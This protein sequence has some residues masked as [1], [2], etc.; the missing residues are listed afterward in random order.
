MLFF[1]ACT[2]T[3][4]P[5]I[6]L[7]VIPTAQQARAAENLRVYQ[8][9]W[10]LVADRHYDPKLQGV[11]WPAAGQQFGAQAA[12][13][14]DDT[15]LYTVLNAMVGLL[16]DSH[17]RVFTP[18]QATER[19]R[20]VRALNGIDAIRL[21]DGRW[22]VSE[23]L[24]GSPAE[25]AGVRPGWVVQ[26]RN[27]RP[28]GESFNFHPRDGEVVRWEFLDARDAPVSLALT[29][30]PL[31]TAPRQLA[32]VL[33]DGF[34]YLRFD[35]FDA[36]DRRW[37]SAQLKEHRSAPGAVL[38]LRRNPGGDTFSLG[39]VIGE[40]FDRS[41]DC[42]TF[43]SRNGAQGEKNS[44]QLG[45]AHFHGRVA[46]LTDGA[47]GSAAEIF[48]AVLQAHGRA[49]VVGRQTAGAVLGSQF[50]GLSDGGELQLSVEDYV[51]PRGARLEGHGVTPDV[52]VP[53]M[54]WNL[55]DLRAQRDPDLAAALRLFA[56]PP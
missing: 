12:M 10:S 23:V 24:P 5:R 43:I 30:H 28:I 46:I 42:G 35:G 7:A 16:K 8:A 26:A 27:G 37:L 2:T 9:V 17:T 19:S 33:P 47:T 36:A 11:D 49:T 41:V 32:R 18:A 25:M 34:I 51:S 31:T 56:A 52:L 53:L 50:Y 55:A 54:P 29:A 14:A 48:S 40:F 6:P 22:A 1:S 38:D 39:T 21:E 44:W 45:S 3:P 4:A 13:A 20:Q 15:A